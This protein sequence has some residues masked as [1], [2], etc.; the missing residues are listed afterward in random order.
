MLEIGFVRARRALVGLVSLAA[1]VLVSPWAAAQ[2]AP[3]PAPAPAPVPT[4][5]LPSTEPEPK[6][7]LTTKRPMMDLTTP[8]PAPPEG[9]TY[10]VHDGLE[11]RVN[12]GLGALLHGGASTDGL[13]DVSTTGLELSYDLLVGG[14][15]SPGFVLGGAVTG[16][17]QLAGEWE[18]DGGTKVG[19]ANL[20]TFVIGP[21]AE[22][23]P[24]AN[25]GLHFG[26]TVGFARIGSDDSGT[27][28][29]ISA[30]GVGGAFWAGSGVWVAP[31]WSIGGLLRLDAATGKD[32]G[33]KLTTVGL[34]AMFSVLY[35]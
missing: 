21:F 33:V 35:N 8:P 16:S 9:R 20:N 13:A 11:V 15:P 24:D 18:L 19:S 22:G 10:H 6:I 4:T 12:V 26:A 5:P 3:T 31:D 7:E 25:G 1:G 34:S 2:T 27:G 14:A 17:F 29:N 28:D 32:N 30:L 23:Y